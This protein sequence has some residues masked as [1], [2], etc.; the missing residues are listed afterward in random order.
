MLVQVAGEV[1][2]DQVQ[3][4][5]P[6]LFEVLPNS[7]FIYKV[8]VEKMVSPLIMQFKY[9]DQDGDRKADL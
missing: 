9:H 8:N 5:K 7:V 6:S 2:Q 4:N 1:P 3:R